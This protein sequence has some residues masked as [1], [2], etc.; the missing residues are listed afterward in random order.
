METG[1]SFLFLQIK[2]ITLYFNAVGNISKTGK[3]PVPK[4]DIPFFLSDKVY[5]LDLQTKPNR[6]THLINFSYLKAKRS[7]YIYQFQQASNHV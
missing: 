1:H 7:Q 3:I 4:G 5:Y 6:L 2:T